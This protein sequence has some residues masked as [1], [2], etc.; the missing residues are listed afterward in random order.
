MALKSV[1]FRVAYSLFVIVTFSLVIEPSVTF[2]S[3]FIKL[4]MNVFFSIILADIF[5]LVAE[6]LL[7]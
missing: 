2:P 6:I 4:H 3:K 7:A 5:I 1:L